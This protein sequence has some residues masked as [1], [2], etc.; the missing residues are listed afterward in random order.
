MNESKENMLKSMREAFE[1]PK[2]KKAEYEI[3]LC[4][5]EEQCQK[6][7]RREIEEELRRAKRDFERQLEEK[8][9]IIEE[10]KSGK[11]AVTENETRK[12]IDVATSK[13][14]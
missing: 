13:V 2:A 1:I 12:N 4:T 5:V 10:I 14:H 7:T 8:D 9:R 11:E 3:K 6:D